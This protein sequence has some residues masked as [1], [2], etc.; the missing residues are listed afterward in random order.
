[1]FLIQ[2]ITSDALQT[3]SL[4]LPDSSVV[5]LQMYFI[6]MQ[7]A[8]V[9]TNLTYGSF[10]LTGFR[11]FNSP[12]MLLQYQ[13]QIPFGIACYSVAN[14]E[15]ALQEDF[16]SGASQLYLLDQTDMAEYYAYLQ[17]GVL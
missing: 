14:R 10:V 5:Q 1:M 12:N 16:S 4:T 3:Q 17:S 9:I 8:W 2:N 15:P 13:N 7:Y 6:P 11:I